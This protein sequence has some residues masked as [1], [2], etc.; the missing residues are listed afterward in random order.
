MQAEQAKG[1]NRTANTPAPENPNF[2]Y[3][4]LRQHRRFESLRSF[5]LEQGQEELDRE[6]RL[7][8]DRGDDSPKVS[9]SM[10]E[11][12]RPPRATLPMPPTPSSPD[13]FE[14]GDDSDSDEAPEADEA[15]TS[16]GAEP[17]PAS[18]ASPAPPTSPTSPTAA[19]PTNMSRAASAEGSAEDAVPL[20]LRGMSE[21]ARGKLPEGAFQRQGSTTSIGSHVSGAAAAAAPAVVGAAGFVP[22]AAWVWGG[23]HSLQTPCS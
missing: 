14:I 19:S 5:T 12:Q 6:N 13:A 23:L 2:I 21:K 17:L 7:R 10:L 18:P 22:T 20:Q 9:F 11:M 16:E 8:K 1:G 3:A 4:I 15:N